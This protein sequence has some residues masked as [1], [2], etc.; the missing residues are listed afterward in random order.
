MPRDL[1]PC[2]VQQLTDDDFGAF[3][4]ETLSGR[5]RDTRPPPVT[6]AMR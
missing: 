3:L 5:L 2:A 1:R 4:R 6:I